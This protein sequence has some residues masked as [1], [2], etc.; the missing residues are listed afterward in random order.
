M[1]KFLKELGKRHNLVD[2]DRAPDDA[3]VR[4]SCGAA[5]E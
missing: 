2:A 1:A 5:A 4:R 3:P